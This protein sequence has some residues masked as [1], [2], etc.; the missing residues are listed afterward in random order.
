VDDPQPEIRVGDRER[1]EVDARLQQ[2]HADGVLTLT[3]YDERA[4][5]CWAART[6]SDLDRLTRDLPPTHP[7]PA[8]VEPAPVPAAD[9]GGARRVRRGVVAVAL[10]GVGLYVGGQAFG[11]DDGTSVFGNREVQIGSTQDRVE[12]GTLFGD[13]TVRVPDDA[14][15]RTTGTVIFG[16]VECAAACQGADR[17]EVVVDAGG[18]FGKVQVLRQNEPSRE[19]DGDRRDRSDDN[20]SNN[21]NDG[22]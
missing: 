5:L 1:R 3:E 21:N 2:A 13:V 20:D 17:R 12:V 22:D 18:G 6:R 16:D 8:A 15:A 19:D 10:I 7:A 11:A 4:A 14:R 9:D